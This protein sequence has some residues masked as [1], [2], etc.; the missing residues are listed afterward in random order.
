MP[1]TASEIKYYESTNGLGGAITA[2]EITT[3]QLHNV[4]DY[5]SSG[6]A[7]AGDIE[8]RCVYVKNTNGSTLT[9]K[10]ALVYI[11][12][13]T[14]SGTTTCGVGLGTSGVGGTEQVIPSESVAPAAVTFNEAEGVGAGLLMGDI[15]ADSYHAIWLRRT[16]SVGTLATSSD[17]MS[18]SVTGDSA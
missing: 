9:L 11:L 2:N 4:F 17:N 18:I 13:N 5:V 12:A 7:S 10:A 8:Y 1:I 6:E 14:P 16:I 3:A 15:P